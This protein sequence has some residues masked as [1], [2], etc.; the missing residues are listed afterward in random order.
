MNNDQCNLLVTACR[1]GD[2]RA[3][4]SLLGEFEKPVF[5]A[6]FR[7]LS[8]YEEARDVTQTAFMKA[9]EKLDQFDASHKFFSWIYRIAI[10]E[11]I[12]SQ[13]ARRPEAT[14]EPGLQGSDDPEQ[15][16]CRDELQRGLQ[17]ALMTLST[18]HRSVVVLKHVLGF[19]Y[20][21]ISD[22]LEVPE[23]TVKSRLH[24]GRERLRGQLDRKAF[25]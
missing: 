13:S 18:E 2:R 6:V 9:F 12:N 24:D 8:D 17:D 14:V 16:V 15:N 22:I 10:N 5:N 23:K 4:D 19:S 1:N 7:M 20:E 3:F 11:C 21:E 25:L